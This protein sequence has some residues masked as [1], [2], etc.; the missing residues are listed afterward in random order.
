VDRP[1]GR[2]RNHP[3]PP[4]ALE[5]KFDGCANL[6]LHSHAT[7]AIADTVLKLETLGDIREVGRLMREGL[8]GD[9]VTSLAAE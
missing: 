3:L 7:Q 1:L 4:G 6:V 2:D 8:R 5:A 9:P